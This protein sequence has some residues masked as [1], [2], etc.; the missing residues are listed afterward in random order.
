MTRVLE[1]RIA[2]GAVAAVGA[3]FS[4][5]FVG[6][7]V[8][9]AIAASLAAAIVGGVIA[10]FTFDELAPWDP[11]AR[12]TPRGTRLAV[13]IIEQSLA[14]CD[15]LARP[16]FMR[17]M[18]ALLISERDDRLARASVVRQMRALLI[19]ELDQRGLDSSEPYDDAITL[20]G[21]DALAILQPHDGNPVTAASIARCLDVIERL[22]T[23]TPENR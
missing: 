15:R 1:K 6:F 7:S 5:W 23:T 10:T 12:E 11:P 20:F 18:R 9:W 19:A 21:P 17:R 3:A 14:A 2:V 16:S 8:F 4:V 22:A 13:V